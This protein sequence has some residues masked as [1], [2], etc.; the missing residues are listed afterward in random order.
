MSVFSLVIIGAI[1]VLVLGIGIVTAIYVAKLVMFQ[2]IVPQVTKN[3]AA[4]Y[5]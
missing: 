2:R 1:G 5:C 4:Q 3:S